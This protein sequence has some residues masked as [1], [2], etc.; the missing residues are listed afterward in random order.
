MAFKITIRLEAG[1]V[2][3]AY[4]TS[5]ADVCYIPGDS[6]GV[7]FYIPGSEDSSHFRK[8][9]RWH[10]RSSYKELDAM[11]VEKD[12]STL[13]QSGFDSLE[14]ALVDFAKNSHPEPLEIAGINTG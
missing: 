7:I 2:I 9:G 5:G 12:N 10:W 3:R 6:L 8:S 4:S 14:E 1:E 11:N 13:H